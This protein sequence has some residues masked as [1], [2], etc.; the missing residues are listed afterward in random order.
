VAFRYKLF[1][2]TD[3]PREESRP[4]NVLSIHVMLLRITEVL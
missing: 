3:I 2:F 1:L 4:Y